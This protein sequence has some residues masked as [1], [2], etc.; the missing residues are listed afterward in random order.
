MDVEDTQPDVGPAVLLEVVE[1][2]V[3]GPVLAA[4]A[5]LPRVALSKLELKLEAIVELEHVWVEER[6]VRE[7]DVEAPPL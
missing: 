7:A 3:A 5:R 1:R 6:V 2:L 4:R